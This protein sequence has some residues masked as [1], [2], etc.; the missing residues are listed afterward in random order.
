[1]DMSLPSAP[2]GLFGKVRL[3][4]RTVG[5]AEVR[6]AQKLAVVGLAMAVAV[7]VSGCQTIFSAQPSTTATTLAG[8]AGTAGHS[9]VIV[10]RP[11]GGLGGVLRSIGVDFPADPSTATSPVLPP[12]A[13]TGALNGAVTQANVHQTICSASWARPAQPSPSFERQ[14]ETL[15]LGGGGTVVVAGAS[16][17]VPGLNEK[18]P[19]PAQ[20]RLDHL[21]P[22]ALGGSAAWRFLVREVE[23][24]DW[25]LP[26]TEEIAAARGSRS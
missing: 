21:V 22:V 23:P 25:Q 14:F 8:S 13:A 4:T 11:G 7:S 10:K 19:V 26:A 2:S 16:Y 5:E 3:V 12:P 17:R 9:G 24:V 1:M 15:E 6:G 18:E 20:F